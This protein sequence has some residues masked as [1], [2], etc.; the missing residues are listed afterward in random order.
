MNKKNLWRMLS[1]MI[2]LLSICF[3]SCEK[4]DSDNLD[5]QAKELMSDLQGEWNFFSGT[6]TV[7]GMTIT[8]DQTFL[9]EMKSAIGSNIKI[10]DETL[11]FNGN[12]LNGVKY[13][14]KNN[15]LILEGMEEFKGITISI[16]SV[17]SSTL[18]LHEIINMEGLNI[19]ADMEYHKK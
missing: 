2:I 7:M 3:T 14:L 18:V 16:Q 4:D 8:I 10:W 13:T 17:T 15:Q 19:V 1:M 5:S 11:N 9:T 12:K 6:E